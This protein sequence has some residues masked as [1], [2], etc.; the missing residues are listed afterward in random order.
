MRL[1]EENGKKAEFEI[2]LSELNLFFNHSSDILVFIGFDGRYKQ[3]SLSFEKI[4]GWKKEEVVSKPFL[5]FVHPDDRERSAAE[6]KA[7]QTGHETEEFENRYRCKDGSY[8]LISWDA[9]PLLEKQMVMGVGR[10]ITELRKAEEALSRQAELIDLSPDA[11]IVE[12]LDGTISFWSKGAEKLYGW[13][14]DEAEGRNIHRLLKS[15]LPQPL[16]EIQNQ[17]KLEGKWSGEIASTCKD[18]SRVVAQSY[19]LAKFGADG[20]VIEMLESNVDISEL[21]RT[22]A[23]LE[24]STI[25]IE[26]Y[27][28]QMEQL[29]KDRAEKLK[30]AECLAAVGA[31]AGMVGHDIRNPLQ[32]IIGDLYLAKAELDST[33]ESEEKKNALE[34]LA[35]IEANIDYINKIVG[36]LQEFAKPLIP[37]I[38]ET[39]LEKILYSTLANLQVP[40]NVTIEHSIQ[41]GFPKIKADKAYL[42]RVLTN[43]ANNAMQ[44]MPNGGQLTITAT[45]GNG[46]AF[47]SVE[48]TGE[49]IPENVRSKLFRPLMTTRSTGHG[50]GLAAVKRFTEGMGGSVSFESVIGKGTKFLIELPTC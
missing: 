16:E 50:F 12:K 4:L 45:S 2:T 29:A 8:R 49:G 39:C 38:E 20:K 40:K 18:G 25:Q 6:A 19:W 30:D 43:L 10:D 35:E 46:K 9:H 15:E 42:Q 36:N 7:R 48:D 31:T 21:I 13:A 26:E 3:V 22:Q 23:K 24:E 41:E 37:N 47:I 28:N 34:S 17:V 11:I 33:P 27:A 44:A 14:K 32:A 1:G 5:D